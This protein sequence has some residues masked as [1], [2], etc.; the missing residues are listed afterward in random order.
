MTLSFQKK[1]LNSKRFVH[2]GFLW[3]QN[4]NKVLRFC[5]WYRVWKYLKKMFQMPDFCLNNS[6][7]EIS[8]LIFILLQ[9]NHNGNSKLLKTSIKLISLGILWYYCGFFYKIFFFSES[10]SFYLALWS[11]KWK[12][13]YLKWKMRYKTLKMLPCYFSNPFLRSL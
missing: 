1:K 5:S 9:I 10:A 11:Q 6:I 13:G 2:V 7:M 4:F 8:T 3:L 12:R